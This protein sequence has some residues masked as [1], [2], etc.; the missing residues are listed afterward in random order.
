[1]SIAAISSA[2]SPYQANSSSFNQQRRTDFQQLAQSLKAGDLSGAQQAFAALQQDFQ[3]V[4]TIQG[5]SS[6]STQVGAVG[7]T[8]GGGSTLTSDLTAV[9]NALQSGNLSSAQNSFATLMQAL[10]GAHHGHHHH[11][12]SGAV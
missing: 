10:Q 12:G 4:S 8:S 3:G 2:Y 1:M 11:Y 5:G 7:A 9:G 6:A